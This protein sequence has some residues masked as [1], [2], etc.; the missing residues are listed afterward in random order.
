MG[1]IIVGRHSY[2]YAERRGDANEIIIG[3]FCS[4]AE[5]VVFDSGYNHE[6]SFIST[7][8][9]S[10]IWSEVKSNIRIEGRNIKIG[11]EVWIGEGTTIMSGISVGSGAIIGT[12]AVVTKDVPPY[13][14]V[15]GVPAKII[16]YRYDQ[17]II[18]KLLLISWWNWSDEKIKE[19]VHLL[20]SDNIREFIEKH[21][22]NP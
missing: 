21:Y 18:N 17:E 3:N 9:F 20:L 14:V 2:S 11:N 7:F 16:R 4:I 10:K 15:G 8:P 5:G 12:K 13:A 1:E 19:N 6:P 22:T